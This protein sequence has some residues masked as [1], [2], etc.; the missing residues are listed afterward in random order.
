[1]PDFVL[2]NCQ[3]KLQCAIVE[4]Q[5]LV[6]SFASA[7][8]IRDTMPFLKESEQS[9]FDEALVVATG[10]ILEPQ[11]QIIL[12]VRTSEISYHFTEEF[13]EEYALKAAKK[14]KMMLSNADSLCNSI[15]FTMTIGICSICLVS[16][17]KNILS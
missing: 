14:K 17:L 6:A 3:E 7:R 16:L 4:R 9:N 5:Y 10:A 15:L 12:I 11:V 13:T 1:M 8:L 2:L